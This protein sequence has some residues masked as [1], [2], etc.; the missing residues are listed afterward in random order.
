MT[1]RT[2]ATFA[3]TAMAVGCVALFSDTAAAITSPASTTPA[4]TARQQG[5]VHD[6]WD[7]YGLVSEGSM[8]NPEAFLRLDDQQQAIQTARRDADVVEVVEPRAEAGEDIAVFVEPTLAAACGIAEPEVTFAFDSA[9]LRDDA[10]GTLERLSA[11]LTEPPLEDAYLSITGHADPM[12]TDEYNR[13]LGLDRAGSVA[14]ALRG[15]GIDSERIDTYSVG[16]AMASD[17]PQAWP[18]QRR[19]VIALDE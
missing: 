5:W 4:E 8:W 2:F 6:Y 16:E 12:G 14:K 3:A 15:R 17:D 19:V 1:H 7:M 10:T 18:E 11:C 13:E 9:R